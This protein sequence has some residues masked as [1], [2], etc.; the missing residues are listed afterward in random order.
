LIATFFIGPEVL[1]AGV[2]AMI[3]S[4]VVLHKLSGQF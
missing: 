4:L 1:I 2:I 3:A